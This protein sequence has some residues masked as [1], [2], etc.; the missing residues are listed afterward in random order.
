MTADSSNRQSERPTE[1]Q[2][3]P[4]DDRPV[5]PQNSSPSQEPPGHRT[6][7]AQIEE[8][9][10][11]S[12]QTYRNLMDLAPDSITVTRRRDGRFMQVNRTFCERTGYTVQETVGR[13]IYELGIYANPSDRER[14]IEA[15]ERDGKIEGMEIQF[16]SKSGRILDNLMSSQPITFE[17]EDCLLVVTANINSLK[18]AQRDLREKEAK[19]RN[20][21]DHITESYY[22]VD[23]SG[24]LTF[25]N[26]TLVQVSG[27]TPDELMG[28]NFRQYTA[29]EDVGRLYAV[30]N[31][32]FRGGTPSR[33]V[34]Y[35]V[36]KKDGTPRIVESSVSLLRDASG[37]PIG[38]YGILRDRTDQKK[39]EDALRQSEESHRGILELAP[40]SITVV[41]LQEGRYL[42]VNDAFC[43][44]SGYSAEEALGR[45]PLELGVYRDPRDR[46]R[47]VERVKTYGSV[48]GLEIQYRNRSGQVLD[49]IVSARQIQFRDRECLLVIVTNI[50]SL[51]QAQEVLRQ[52]EL[53]YRTVLESME[54]GYYETDLRGQFTYFNA[55]TCRLHGYTADELMGMSYKRYLRPDNAKRISNI[56]RNIYETGE[57]STVMEY[58]IIRKDGSIRQCELSAYLRRDVSGRPVGFWGITR[59][60]TEQKKMESQ[61][62][63]SSK[64]ESIGT[65][66]GGLAHDFNNLLMGIQGNTTLILMD[67]DE[68]HPSYANLKSIEQYVRAGADLTRQ[69]LGAARGGKYEVKPTPMNHVI[70]ATAN[71][72]GR[73]R[74]EITMHLE[75]DDALWMAAVDR[76]Q[77]EQVLLNLF[78]N[79]WH[80][81]PNGGDL[82]LSSRNSVL[83]GQAARSYG[84][85][86]GKYIIISVT[87]TGVGIAP[88]AINRIFDPFFTT[89]EMGHGTGLGLASVYGILSNHGGTITVYSEQGVGTTFN[90]YLPATEMQTG[91]QKEVKMEAKTGNETVLLVDDDAGIVEV[92]RLILEKLGYRVLT[93]GN[94]QAAITTFEQRHDTIDLV[95]LDMIMPGMSGGE[96]FSEMKKIDPDVR[97]I[98]SSGYSINGQ[99]KTILEG[100]CR[101]FIQKPYNIKELSM[102]LREVLNR[103]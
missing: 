76:G 17:G 40:D 102:K 13:T 91:R 29:S 89:K 11:Q 39:A 56:F 2:T 68:D 61:L 66:A 72:F 48:E 49:A 59:D 30:F 90:I 51:K 97:V 18:Q 23:L 22:E 34:D 55:S 83:E 92:G 88:E 94:G 37:A 43:R 98:L 46:D 1:R 93:A 12:E 44:L 15:L 63:H 28:M 32:I 33:I 75:M 67:T 10:R 101:G 85:N 80:A 81:M 52:S 78:V 38:F 53:K 36:R 60:R 77:M 42:Q 62:L 64:M 47:L 21:L 14:V 58:E 25:F 74:K 87:D 69:L 3:E 41:D 50:T 70:E 24:N 5:H 20:I 4:N 84:L 6:D 19:L 26:D 65:L 103:A 95:L 71:L 27:Y 100:G 73:T 45:T 7:P 86:P 35:C 31:D 8:A 82:F 99:A 96:T 54:E 9:L 16:K 79:A 57:H